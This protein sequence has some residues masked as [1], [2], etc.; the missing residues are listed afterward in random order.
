MRETSLYGP[1]TAKPRPKFERLKRLITIQ[2]TH[3]HYSESVDAL[4]KGN[5][6]VEEAAYDRKHAV[7]LLQV[8]ALTKVS[9]IP[10]EVK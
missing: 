3:I 4:E 2:P 6:C 1:A 5:Y 8:S 7:S 10:Q 9:L